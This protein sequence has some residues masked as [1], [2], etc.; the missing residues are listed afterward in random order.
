MSG[1]SELAAI[2]AI[3]LQPDRLRRSAMC[4]HGL[5]RGKSSTIIVV[6]LRASS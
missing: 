4:R 6:W 1:G 5:H 2:G 3:G